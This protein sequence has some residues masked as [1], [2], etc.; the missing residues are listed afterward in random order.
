MAAGL[1]ASAAVAAGV[2]AAAALAVVGGWALFRFRGPD[3]GLRAA[4]RA[5][6]RGDHQAALALARRARPP[7]GAA[8]RSWHD[9]QRQLEAEA[10]YAAA[11][12][13]LRERRFADALAFYEVVA[14]LLGLDKAEAGRRVVEAMLAEA[15][16]LS[17]AEPD[18]AALPEILGHIL[19]RQSRCPEA[20]F[21]L[22]LYRLRR[23]DNQA[24]TTALT[25]AHDAAQGRPIDPALYLGAIWLREGKPREAL[26]VLADANRIVPN[27][28][29]VAWQL[30]VALL[31]SGGDALLALRALQKA[32][33][34]DGF[35][36]YLRAPHRLWAETLSADSWVRNVSQRAGAQGSIFRCPLGLDQIASV[37]Q[38][39]RLTLAETLVTCERADEAVPVFA[40]LLR[41][42]DSLAVRRG[43]GLALL[44]LGRTDEALPHLHRAHTA[45]KPPTAVTT[46]ALAACLA[47]AGGD[48]AANARHA[49]GLIASLNVRADANW[50]RHAGAV[51]AAAQAAGVGV[52]AEEV[53]E[54]AAV[55]VSA[56]A[57]DPTAAA[58]YNLL[59]TLQPQ[60][61]S[62]E[63]AGLYVRA[64]QRHGVNLPLDEFLFD[65]A[66]ADR[67]ATRE[68]FQ[69]QEWDFDAAERQY[70]ERWAD[71]HPGTYPA[72][73][74]IDYADEAET[75]LLADANRLLSQRRPEDARGVAKLVLKLNP[76]SGPAHDRLAE[77]AF[78]GGD[79]TA[80][81]DWLRKWRDR[82]P[83]DPLPLI[84]LAAF[85]AADRR[86]AEGLAAAHQA[87][88][89]V[90]GVARVPVLILAARLA[91]GADKRADAAT[92]FDECLSL[93]PNNPVALAGRSALAWSEGKF[94]RL[95]RLSDRMAEV[96]AEDPWFHY[97]AGAALL[98]AG[99]FDEAEVSA[100]Y[101]AGD[102]ATAAEGR[103]LLAL[104]RDRRND[105]AGAADLL[106]D[107]A[108]AAGAAGQ[109][110]VALRGQAAW[111]GGDYVEALRCWQTLPD[112]RL[113][114]WNLA[115]VIGGTAFLAG[116][117][118][119]R[120]GD[121]EDACRWLRKAAEVGHPDPRLE[122]L[123]AAACA[124]AG[125]RAGD[126]RGIELLEQAAEAGGPRPEIVRRLARGYRRAGRL[127]DARRLLD[128]VLADDASLDLER[129][130]LLL[131]EGH[132]VPAE[133]AFATAFDHDPKSAAAAVNLV[134]TRLSLGRVAEAAEL[135]P[136]AA[137]LA[138]D[139]A[140]KRLLLELH[141]LATG[142]REPPPEWS[143]ADDKTILQCLRSLG[144]L[145]SIAP[146]VDSLQAFRA[147]SPPVKHAH[148][149]LVPLR[150]R[151]RLDRGD[152]VAA[153]ELLEPLAG[154]N[155]PP[156]VQNLLGIC[157]ALRSEFPRAVR[158][159]QAALPPVGD[160]ARVQ[161]NLAL[162]RGWSDDPER[163][164][165]HWRRFLELH[166]SQ[167]RVP[168]GVADYH[169]RIS[170]LV[171]EKVKEAIAAQA[172]RQPSETERHAR[173]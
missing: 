172:D 98:L 78:R 35:P 140:L 132:P 67:A 149:E 39:A 126:H 151:D 56:D 19:E 76:A 47:Q 18:N 163:S 90:R 86:P 38:Q 152:P 65:R 93:D 49:L 53:A 114:T 159:F 115:T 37:L 58:V 9:E 13:A 44:H 59:A 99:R 34:P 87:L 107:P 167:M 4:R 95:I 11:E 5:L 146:L 161:Q 83:N 168:A 31:Q 143:V 94:A 158:R 27:C 29:L 64:A 79:R 160:D 112:G 106:K 108:V 121:A 116:V 69:A 32:T 101:A 14:G 12:V 3:L 41:S 24:G 137:V 7:A 169:R 50:A 62:V 23:G 70:L 130:L 117:Q 144:R 153:R 55:L 104:V 109:H 171:R 133:R 129:G 36:K 52:S 138:P 173:T 119:L 33:G 147:Q 124:G 85:D 139:P 10:L 103:H 145:E 113:K 84:R 88:D 111:R 170:A 2:V 42:Q 73:P 105:P 96:Q 22:G 155:A 61:V 57:A 127:A 40:D 1:L 16:R 156:V 74:G 71:R 25:T 97:L 162:V 80:A 150:A 45:E 51:F 77:L 82:C 120:A 48:R 46:G 15:R 102:P 141:A 60:A 28:P 72:A 118:A 136:R 89:R 26:R 21:W 165:A 63:A 20:S 125:T 100:R 135:M 92:L 122:S 81:A 134:F 43:L 30:G 6:E 166:A 68:L 148:A 110:A 128:T 157:A 91:V 123:L 66:M 8:R 75:A 142:A 164:V 54:L 17:V 131:A 154:P